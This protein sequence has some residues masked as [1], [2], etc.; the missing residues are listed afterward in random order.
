MPSN[1]GIVN[2]TINVTLRDTTAK[3]PLDPVFGIWAA[4]GAA[5]PGTQPFNCN[6][7]GDVNAELLKEIL[8]KIIASYPIKPISLCLRDS[9][10][11][12]DTQCARGRLNTVVR[13]T[14]DQAS[15]NP[16]MDRFVVDF[17]KP[18]PNGSGTMEA[19][20]NDKIYIFQ[21]KIYHGSTNVEP[22][23][24]PEDAPVSPGAYTT[25]FTVVYDPSRIPITREE[26]P[27][28]LANQP[29]KVVLDI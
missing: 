9:V 24:K 14:F 26:F 20:I 22:I 29:V 19:S 17:S 13:A 8:Q 18:F 3:Q 2:L 12:P 11:V 10:I 27:A 28:V 15:N 16:P 23:P 21:L 7:F 6:G 5:I 1:N 25:R 4:E